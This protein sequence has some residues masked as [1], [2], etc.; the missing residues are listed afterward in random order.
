MLSNEQYQQEQYYRALVF[1]LAQIAVER[2]AFITVYPCEDS[3]DKWS[4]LIETNKDG[5]AWETEFNCKEDWPTHFEACQ[6]AI[7]QY[8]L[9]AEPVNGQAID[10]KTDT[11]TASKK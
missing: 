7:K 3:W 1:Q 10:L 6:A 4:F 8:N 2:K 11:A 5:K 9:T